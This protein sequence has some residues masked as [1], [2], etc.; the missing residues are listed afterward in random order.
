MFTVR[1]RA[2]DSLAR[3]GTLHLA[4]GDVQTPAF[5]PLA[6]KGAV[7]TL[8]PRDVAALGYELVLGNTF[9]LLLA[10]G[11]ELVARVRRPARVHALG[12]SRS[13]PTRAAFRCSRWATATSPT[14]S[15]AGGAGRRPRRQREG[16]ILSIEEEGVRFR[17]Y[18]DGRERFLGPETLDGGPGRAAAPTSRSCSTSARR[19]TSPASTPRAR[20]SAPTAGSSAACA[21]TREHGP[22][23]PGRVR[24]R[25]GRRRARPAARVGG[26][27]R[28]ER[29]RRDRDRRL[30]RA[31]TSRRC[32]RSSRGRRPSS[33]ASRPSARAT[34]SGSATSTT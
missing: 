33:S 12:A 29:L 34:C 16:A 15:R 1:T 11:P 18:V 13:S 3:T 14:R 17:S 19:F 26:R 23:R 20:S 7:K 30:A 6:T 22:P 32:T 28:G 21:G 2:A 25:P 31:A 10:P 4:H 8:E 24:H 9:H 27:G 5:V